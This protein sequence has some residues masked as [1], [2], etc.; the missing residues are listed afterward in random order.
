M[1]PRHFHRPKEHAPYIAP[2]YEPYK[3]SGNG[4]RDG[5]NKLTLDAL[6]ST[7][8]EILATEHHL[9]L[10]QPPALPGTPRKENLDRY[11]DYHGEK[12]HYT[13]DC[14]QLKKQLEVALESGKLNHL[15]KD[16][17]QRGKAQK[18]NGPQK[19]KVINMVNLVGE[20]RKRKSMF[21]DEAW[22]NVPT[23][24]PPV[25]AEDLS[26]AA[27]VVEDEIEGYLVKRIHV[28]EGASVEIMYMQCFDNFHPTIR[29]R[30]VEIHTALSGFSGEQLKPLG[31]IELEVCFGNDGL[32]A[33]TTMKFIVVSASS[34]YNVILGRSGLKK[35]RAIPSTIHSM[36][37]FPTPRG[38]ATLVTQS[39]SVY[40]C[41][42]EKKRLIEKDPEEER[43]GK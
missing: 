25:G 27:I 22:Q 36:M 34:P 20:D 17:R 10:P 42:S 13:N 38:I 26:E 23:T 21:T 7:L 8:K 12:G 14:Y 33:R 3:H 9:R 41:R 11:C 1:G 43:R 2:R 5:K 29:A 40:E 31:K 4:W 39:V 28:D 6:A 32:C 35:S 24:F 30:L 15:V 37:K 16:V 19:A 18:N